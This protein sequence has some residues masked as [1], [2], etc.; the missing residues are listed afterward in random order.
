M[1][2]SCRM[3]S[4]EA[5]QNSSGDVE[6]YSAFLCCCSVLMSKFIYEGQLGQDL[7]FWLVS[8]ADMRR[9]FISLPRLGIWMP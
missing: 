4:A 2:T 8:S 5:Q 1:D 9:L 7:G 3:S 6:A